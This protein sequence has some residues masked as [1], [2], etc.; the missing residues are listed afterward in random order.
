MTDNS[1][2]TMFIIPGFKMS[3]HDK[4]FSWLVTFLENKGLRVIQTPVKWNYRTL[5]QNTADFIEYYNKNKSAENYILGFSYGAVIAFLTASTLA[6]KG[7]FLCSLSPDFEEDRIFMN[8]EEKKYIGKRRY[9]DTKKRSSSKIA[10]NLKTPV[11]IFYGEKEGD[12]YPALKKRAKETARLAQKSKLIVVKDA[13]HQIEAVF[14]GNTHEIL[15]RGFDRSE[16]NTPARITDGALLQQCKG[17]D[18]K[19]CQNTGCNK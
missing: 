11:V 15:S 9:A 12:K 7:I 19:S 5:S 18:C 10:K 6:P 16:N 17:C 8:S 1:K 13:P 14:F 2:K 4:A 3:P